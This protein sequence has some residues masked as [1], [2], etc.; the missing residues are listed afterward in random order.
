MADREHEPTATIEDWWKPDPGDPFWMLEN[1][2]GEWL[3]NE[4]T[5][6]TTRDPAK[7]IRYPSAQHADIARRQLLSP[8]WLKFTP[9][10]HAWIV[11]DESDSRG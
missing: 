9:T 10:E 6:L 2:T 11:P 7:A 3:K 1:S 8:G 4:H 5:Q